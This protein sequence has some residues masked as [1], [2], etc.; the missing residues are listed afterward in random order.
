MENKNDPNRQPVKYSHNRNFLIYD[1]VKAF[2]F[3][4]QF[5]GNL[6]AGFLVTSPRRERGE[7]SD[8]FR[9]WVYP[10][11]IKHS[12]WLLDSGHQLIVTLGRKK[13]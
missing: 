6:S 12:W 4:W 2:G 11:V 7:G 9:W 1:S 5:V 8:M 3:C 10:L 13:S